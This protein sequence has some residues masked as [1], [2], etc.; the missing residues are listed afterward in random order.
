MPVW[1]D[2]ALLTTFAW[3]GLLLGFASVYLV[4]RSV[5]R[6][7]GAVAGWCVAV[8][9]LALSG[10]GIYLGRELRWN[11]WD[12]LVQPGSVLR[13]SL[14]QLSTA[15]MVGMTLVMATFLTLA[16]G[17]LYTAFAAAV[18]ERD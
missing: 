11:S 6:L 5:Q 8:G 2:V 12:L 9:A 18:E 7:A 13:E 17:M 16:Y 3:T 4:Q 15:R 1:F 14:E 10:V